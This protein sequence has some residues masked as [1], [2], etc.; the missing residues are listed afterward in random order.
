MSDEIDVV[1]MI[2][3][4]IERRF[5]HAEMR[6]EGDGTIEGY[7][8]VFNQWSED[9]GGFREM[10][11]RGAFSKTLKEADV[12]GLFNHDPNYVLGR[13]KSG[14]LDL[15][16]DS[17]GL[18]F[19]ARAPETGWANDLRES[20]RRG[21]IDQASFAFATVRD[22]W[23]RAKDNKGV[24]ERELVEVKLFDVSVVT[25]P[26]YP[27]TQVSAR[28]LAEMFIARMEEQGD[29]ETIQYMRDQLAELGAAAAPVQEDHPA[30]EEQV[31]PQARRNLIE[32]KRQIDKLRICA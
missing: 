24:H 3:E 5:L 12:R 20:I 11:R 14:T 22:E 29:P 18:H 31:Q 15:A 21:D 25:Y 30:D 1:S 8:S 6:V 28:S 2:K 26:A 23:K 4:G 19:R 32:L 9:L 16:E 13:N 10:V 17:H 7:A 27:Q